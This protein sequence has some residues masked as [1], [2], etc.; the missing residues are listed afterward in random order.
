M[1]R[2]IHL[3]N[4]DQ[5][6]ISCSSTVG[7]CARMKRLALRRARSLR[8]SGPEGLEEGGGGG[9]E[10]AVLGEGGRG[11]EGTVSL[12]KMPLA[13]AGTATSP[14]KLLISTGGICAL[15]VLGPL[16]ICRR[17]SASLPCTADNL[18]RL[19]STKLATGICAAA[20]SPLILLTRSLLRRC[21]RSR[22]TIAFVIAAG[23]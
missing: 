5:R 21:W 1:D 10:N 14:L 4:L 18:P 2:D 19:G 20:S 15:A 8:G 16:P 22:R 3:G 11:V 7:S 13:G 17:K 6:S 9:G 12:F 23:Q